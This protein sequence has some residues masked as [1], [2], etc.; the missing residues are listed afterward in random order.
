MYKKLCDL[1]DSFV[2]KV[3]D[4]VADFRSLTWVIITII[5]LM[6]YALIEIRCH[7][8]DCSNLYTNE[9]KDNKPTTVI[10]PRVK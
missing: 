1:L 2:E 6:I 7:Y 10:I 5:I 3:L 4:R 8:T 9:C